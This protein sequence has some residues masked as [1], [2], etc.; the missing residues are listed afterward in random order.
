MESQVK[1]AI[2]NRQQPPPVEVKM[3][4]QAVLRL[5]MHMGPIHVVCPCLHQGQIKGAELL[6]N[7]LETVKIAR[8]TT[9]EIRT[10]SMIITQEA[11][12]VWL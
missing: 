3:C 7:L 10:S 11:Q 1:G 5:H 6:S 9:E 12:R 8:V 4:L 2:V